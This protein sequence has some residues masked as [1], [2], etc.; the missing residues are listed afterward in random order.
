MINL[1][2]HTGKFYMI[3]LQ[4]IFVFQNLKEFLCS[5]EAEVSSLASLYSVVVGLWGYIFEIF[6]NHL[7]AMLYFES[8]TFYRVGIWML[9]LLILVKIHLAALLSKVCDC[10][11]LIFFWT[12][13]ILCSVLPEFLSWQLSMPSNFIGSFLFL[14]CNL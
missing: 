10:I 12:K 7:K 5:A 1:Y 2:C 11:I 8:L 3:S 13:Y 9:W 14:C 6:I 4:T